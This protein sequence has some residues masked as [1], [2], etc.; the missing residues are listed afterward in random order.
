MSILELMNLCCCFFI[1]NE[2]SLNDDSFF[3]FKESGPHRDL[4]FSPT[5]PSPDPARDTAAINR[6][7]GFLNHP[8]CWNDNRY[9]RIFNSGTARLK[10][11]NYCEPKLGEPAGSPRITK[12]FRDRK[13]TRLNS[14]HLVISYAVFCLKK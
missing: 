6:R 10:N 11:L 8:P 14:S 12:R 1:F 4:P 3:F 2:N 13:S 5:R 9:R 7:A